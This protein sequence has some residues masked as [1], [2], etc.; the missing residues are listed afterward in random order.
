[1]NKQENKTI[2]KNKRRKNKMSNEFNRTVW[3]TVWNIDLFQEIQERL[4][5]E[6]IQAINA[7]IGRLEKEN[8]RLRERLNNSFEYPCK[9][10]GR[11][12]YKTKTQAED[13]MKALEEKGDNIK[14]KEVEFLY[15]HLWQISLYNHTKKEWYR[16]FIEEKELT[17]MLENEKKMRKNYEQTK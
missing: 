15:G 12:Y 9:I 2:I 7:E 13:H 4:L 11:W 6:E 17:E 3:N 1:M 8:A 10:R 5:P 14:I 16:T